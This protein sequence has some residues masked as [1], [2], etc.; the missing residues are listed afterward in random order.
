MLFKMLLSIVF[1]LS[2]LL[3]ASVFQ[4]PVMVR[5]EVIPIRV[6]TLKSVPGVSDR[7]HLNVELQ[8]LSPMKKACCFVVLDVSCP[9]ELGFVILHP[10]LFLANSLDLLQGDDVN[11]CRET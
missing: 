6:V 7:L 1:D 3:L 10:F 4:R 11:V 2:S 5:L 9:W 8:T